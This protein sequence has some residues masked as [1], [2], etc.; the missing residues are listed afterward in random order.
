M[1]RYVYCPSDNELEEA[2]IFAK[3][4]D[5]PVLIGDSQGTESLIFD[6]S[7]VQILQVPENKFF[8]IR[9]E[10]VKKNFHQFIHYKNEYER[11]KGNVRLEINGVAV[12]ALYEEI[13]SARFNFL[14][15]HSG[16]YECILYLNNIKEE[17]LSFAVN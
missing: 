1:K 9:K 5:L 13:H 17:E 7:S 3:K 10:I 12:H 16:D 2:V 14:C 6:R 8:N 4:I 11:I 15:E